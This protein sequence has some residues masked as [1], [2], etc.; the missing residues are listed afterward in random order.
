M[1][2]SVRKLS[3]IVIS[4]MVLLDL[5]AANACPTCKNALSDSMAIAYAWSIGFLLVV[6]LIMIGIWIIALRQLS[7]QPGNQGLIN[8]GK[9]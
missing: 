6:P 2:R 4:S 1:K 5:P 8:L 9:S 3:W 7:R